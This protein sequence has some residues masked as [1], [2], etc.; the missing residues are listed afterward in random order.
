[1][2]SYSKGTS[3]YIVTFVVQVLMVCPN[4][5]PHSFIAPLVSIVLFNSEPIDNLTWSAL[6][7]LAEV[8]MRPPYTDTFIY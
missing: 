5:F 4:K 2:C 3:V 6:A 1:M 8:G 7:T